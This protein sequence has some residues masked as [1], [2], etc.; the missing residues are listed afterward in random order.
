MSGESKYEKTGVDV[1]KNA[2]EIFKS[3]IGSLYPTAFCVIKQDPDFPD[4]V[5]VA[6]AD[7]AGSKPVQHYLNFK[8][9]NDVNCFKGIAQDVVAMNLD[10]IICVG[11]KPVSF[12][13]YVSINMLTVPKGEFLKIL[14]DDIAELIHL[15]E[16]VGVNLPFDGGETADHPDQLHTLDVSGFMQGRARMRD[17]ITGERIR[18]GNVIVGLRSGGRARYE[19][20]ENSGIMCNGITLARHCLM[21][22]MYAEKYPEIGGREK[23]GGYYGRLKVD[24][25]LDEL[26]MTVGEAITSPTRI[27][28]PVIYKVLEAT[29][30]SVTGL[31]HNTQG[32]LTKSLKLGEN[33]VYVKDNLLE[34]DPIFHLIQEESGESWREMFRDFNMGCGFEVIAEESAAEEII[35]ISENLGIQAQVIGRTEERSQP[36]KV[37]IDSDLGKFEYERS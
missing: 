18:S 21:S 15:M 32:G 20:H 5:L 17:L 19:Q 23:G 12:V 14:N 1:E 37:L 30:S 33:L 24:D 13:D 27:F 34:I 22:S 29:A 2:V 25:F 6:H 26:G 28:S 35:K 10:D 7:G 16:S 11:A 9:S 3:T 4:Y 31:V 36:N 8:E